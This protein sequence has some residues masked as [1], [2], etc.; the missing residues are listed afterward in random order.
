MFLF[1]ILFKKFAEKNKEDSL[2][3]PGFGDFQLG[4]AKHC[5]NLVTRWKSSKPAPNQKSTKKAIRNSIFACRTTDA[6]LRMIGRNF[7]KALNQNAAAGRG[8]I[9]RFIM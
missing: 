3:G 8:R 4:W 1:S 5:I 2:I 6:R 9:V 7:E